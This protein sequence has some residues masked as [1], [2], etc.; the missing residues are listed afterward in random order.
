MYKDHAKYIPKCPLVNTAYLL[1]RFIDLLF[2]SS[3][4]PTTWCAQI[5][6]PRQE[7]YMIPHVNMT[8][9]KLTKTSLDHDRK[10]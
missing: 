8:E 6:L 3:F 7:N 9:H 10:S 2:Q 1:P 5:L 4:S